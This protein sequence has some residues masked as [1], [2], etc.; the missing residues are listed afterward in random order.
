MKN[1]ILYIIILLLLIGCNSK[2]SQNQ[3]E[4]STSLIDSKNTPIVKFKNN[5][6]ELKFIIDTGSEIS[7]I[8][9]D[10]YLNHLQYFNYVSN[11]E[12]DINT[13]SGTV[14]SGVIIA[15]TV[16][17]DSLLSQ[18]YITD[19]DNIKKEVF[20]NTGKNIDGILGCDFLYRNKSIID[21]KH[22]VLSNRE[23]DATV[24]H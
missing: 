9:D 8:D 14:S 23:Y 15:T 4:F 22:K 18:F 11:T 3:K 2:Q 12:C 6:S 10:Y 20:I 1:T 21:F 13:L 19:I 7:I 16:L 5:K 17:D 24:Q